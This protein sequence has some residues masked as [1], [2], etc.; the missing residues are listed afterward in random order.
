MKSSRYVREKSNIRSEI[1]YFDDNMNPAEIKQQG[2]LS[3]MW[4]RMAICSL[5]QKASLNSYSRVYPDRW[6]F[7]RANKVVSFQPILS[8]PT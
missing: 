6:F 3:G 8:L 4:M 5:K 1:R 7:I 2:R